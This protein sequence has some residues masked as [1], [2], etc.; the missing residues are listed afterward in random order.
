[1]NRKRNHKYA[2][3]LASGLIIAL[4]ATGPALDLGMPQIHSLLI[5][6]LVNIYIYSSFWLWC[7]VVTLGVD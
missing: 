1:V 2:F 7:N 5:F 6:F 3:G 4:G